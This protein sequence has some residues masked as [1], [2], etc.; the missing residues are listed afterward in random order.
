MAKLWTLVWLFQITSSPQYGDGAAGGVFA[1]LGVCGSR[2]V[3]F[4]WLAALRVGSTT[5]R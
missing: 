3:I 4:T 5:A 1:E 2:T